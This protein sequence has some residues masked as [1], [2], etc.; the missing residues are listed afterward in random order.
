M[1]KKKLPAVFSTS[2]VPVHT[3]QQPL[4]NTDSPSF[5]PKSCVIAYCWQILTCYLQEDG[6]PQRFGFSAVMQVKSQ[7]WVAVMPNW[8][9]IRKPGS[10]HPHPGG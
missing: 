2:F 5:A 7:K 4:G 9:Q 3:E 1:L 8:K 6:N 10:T